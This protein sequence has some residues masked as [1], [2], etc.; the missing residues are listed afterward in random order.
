VEQ[1][2]GFVAMDWRQPEIEVDDAAR[3]AAGA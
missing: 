3:I 2:P 1:T